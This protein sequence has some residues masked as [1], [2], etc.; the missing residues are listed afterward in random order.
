[1]TGLVSGKVSYQPDPL[2]PPEDGSVLICC[3]Q[4]D[5]EVML[6]L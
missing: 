4:P 6:D 1:V 5:N 3:S 2:E